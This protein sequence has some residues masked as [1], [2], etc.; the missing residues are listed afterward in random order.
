M[1]TPSILEALGATAPFA[2]ASASGG[3]FK[4]GMRRLAGGV[5]VV[6]ALGADGALIGMTATAVCSLSAEPPTLLV[7]AN[8]SGSF[9]AQAVMGGAFRVHVLAATQEHVARQCAGMGGERGPERFADGHWLLDETA[10]PLLTNALA[11]FDCIVTS[12][13]PAST[14][15]LT[16][17]HVTN[18]HLVDDVDAALAYCEGQ[19]IPVAR[20]VPAARS[21]Q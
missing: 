8:R 7:C 19:F 3:L 17:G 10:A 21:P 16:I 18:V 2:F 4:A 1:D 11:R 15:L 9:A 6:T 12:L 13:I 14:H 20:S 5:T